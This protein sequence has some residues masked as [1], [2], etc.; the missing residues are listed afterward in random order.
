MT[1]WYVLLGVLALAG[2]L[3]ALLPMR[4]ASKLIHG[5]S[6]REELQDE[7][8]TSLKQ[9]GDLERSRADGELDPEEF[10]RL[11]LADE[12]RA[13]RLLE[14]LEQLPEAQ[15]V[16]LPGRS[17]PALWLIGLAVV[18][19]GFSVLAV[20]SLQRLALPENEAKFYDNSQQ[21]LAFEAQLTREADTLGKPKL[22][23]LALYGD[24]AW[25]MQDWNRAA[26]AYSAI[27][28]L[29]PTNIVAV[30]RY[31]QLLFFSGEND[32]A[33]PLLQAAA[34]LNNP[35][36]MLTLGNLLFSA[37]NDPQGALNVWQQYQQVTGKDA[38]PRVVELIA[39]A[40]KRL[41]ATATAD[42]G[43][44]VFAANCA[45]CHGAE[46]QGIAGNGPNLIASSNA[47]SPA[48]VTRQVKQG[49]RNGKMPAFPQL[50]QAQLE[51][52]VKFV[53]ALKP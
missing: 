14:R 40:K 43:A 46:A 38:A 50:S 39:A 1:V 49:S 10:E 12:T 8:N 3:Y 6:E 51:A 44:Q 21:L 27:L 33:L 7:L 31:G 47:R 26:P 29:D 18:F 13:A 37:K 42:P 34:K 19:G 48:F 30:S 9:I 4:S 23:T 32:Q 5:K 2:V 17:R 41:Q 11:K 52:V 22:E 25:S 15:P 53:T 36:A 45:T 16:S 24:L 20:P 35:E 28:R